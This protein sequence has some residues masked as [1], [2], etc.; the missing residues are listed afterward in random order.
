MFALTVWMVSCVPWADRGVRVSAERQGCDQR[1]RVC[2]ASAS[3]VLR[4]DHVS[5]KSRGQQ[6][7]DLQQH[8]TFESELMIAR[9]RR[10]SRGVCSVSRKLI[11]HREGRLRGD[12]VVHRFSGGAMTEC[13]VGGELVRRLQCGSFMKTAGIGR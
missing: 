11:A 10:V 12:R 13:E 5:G 2:F 9:Q 1:E 6:R 4:A 3:P 8:A 7:H